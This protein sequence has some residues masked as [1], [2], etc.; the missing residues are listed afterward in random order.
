MKYSK[1]YTK[2]N[3]LHCLQINDMQPL[4]YWLKMSTKTMGKMLVTLSRKNRTQNYGHSKKRTMKR[5][6]E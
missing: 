2:L 3:E 6:N 1:I 5:K 4:K